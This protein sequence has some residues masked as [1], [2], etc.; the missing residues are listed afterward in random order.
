MNALVASFPAV[1]LR[2]VARRV[3][4]LPATTETEVETSYLFRAVCQAGDEARISRLSL[5]PSVTSLSWN[6]CEPT[7]LTAAGA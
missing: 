7:V 4:R 6:V 3:G 2:P 5:E 1:G